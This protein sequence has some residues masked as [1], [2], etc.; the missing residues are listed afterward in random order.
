MSA[1][2]WIATI[3][4]LATSLIHSCV[5]FHSLNSYYSFS[6]R[7][8]IYGKVVVRAVKMCTD[9]DSIAVRAK[10]VE[11]SPFIASEIKHSDSADLGFVSCPAANTGSNLALGIHLAGVVETVGSS[12]SPR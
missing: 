3:S 9:V 2:N 4:I 1:I 5:A 11:K 7:S 6:Q 12:V 8:R 10:H